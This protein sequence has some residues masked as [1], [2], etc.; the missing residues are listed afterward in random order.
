MDTFRIDYDKI[1]VEAIMAQIRQRV[2]EKKEVLYSDAELEHLGGLKLPPSAEPAAKDPDRDAVPLPSVPP[3]ADGPRVE[4]RITDRL[5]E[6]KLDDIKDEDF[7]TEALRCVGDW[8]IAISIDDLYRSSPGLK[9]K[10][11][12]MVRSINRRLFKLVM[13][14]DVLFPQL[15]KQAILNQTYVVLLHT[16]VQELSLLNNK[17]DRLAPEVSRLQGELTSS[18]QTLDADLKRTR[19]ELI[20]DIVSDKNDFNRGINQVANE[21]EKLEFKIDGL[22]GAIEGQKHQIE[23]LQARQ[24][25]LE[26]LAVLKDEQ[27]RN[28]RQKTTDLPRG[29]YQAG[30]GKREKRK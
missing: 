12:R 27:P 29:R 14:I 16:L 26:E 10:I 1:D 11:V 3:K 20:R 4:E 7:V 22:R 13:N 21:I 6:V 25:A 24:R 19:A 15:H 8:N 5:K 2:R 30:K 9:G 18:V 28:S 17:I 23:Y